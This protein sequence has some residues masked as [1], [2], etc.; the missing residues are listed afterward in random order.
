MG[1]IT[2]VVGT[3]IL[4][5]VAHVGAPSG[6][7]WQ[8]LASSVLPEYV[9]NTVL[10]ALGV[11][12]VTCVLGVATA[13]LVTLCRFPG[14]HFFSWALLLPLAIPTY[15]A[16]YAYSDLFQFAGPVQTG[17]RE[18]FGWGRDDYWFPEVRSLSG[19]VGILSLGLYPYVYLAART[20]FLEQ[21]VCV[22][23]VGRTL[24]L[25]PWRSFARIALP[26]ARPSIL[27]GLSLVLM[28]TLAEFGAVEY[29]AVNTFATGIYRVFTQPNAYALTAAAQLS[30]CL[31]GLVI[32]LLAAESFARRAARFHHTSTRY[33]RLPS[34]RLRGSRGALA[35]VAC[36]LPVAAGFGLPL[37]I[38]IAK[39]WRFGDARAR[40][41]FFE[42]GRNTFALAAVASL[43]AVALAL[44]V[45]FCR[46]LDGGA[47][48]R[49]LARLAGIGYAI[50]GGVIAIGILITVT[51]ADHRAQAVAGALFGTAP[52][53]LWSGTAVALVYGYQTRFLAVS[54]S[55]VQAGLTRI[56]PSVDG[57]ARTLGA[58]PFGMVRRV[59]LPLLRGTLLS[60]ALLVFVDVIKELPATLIL[61]PFDFD[62]LAV[63]VYHLASD[64]RLDE[65]ST[66]ALA[67]I[68]VGLVPVAILS[69]MLERSRPGARDLRPAPGGGLDDGEPPHPAAPLPPGVL[70]R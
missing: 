40:E 52:G 37:L 18:L 69:R 2:A 28:E 30:A 5:V 7:L 31:L 8:H 68:L 62:T 1:L 47:W 54:L 57:A 19:A 61:R 50:P 20:A 9:R 41:I 22:L 70:A 26:L 44:A 49:V 12:T 67:I 45:A 63:R 34:W 35:A 6:G 46:R 14:R 32:L 21:S 36:A 24:G 4:V 59:H 10:L 33:R 51:W 55:F 56:R 60:A 23:E 3:P 13:W 58:S 43:L 11:G 66:G 53:M 65:A 39:T 42:I 38:F 16:A 27:A 15:L 25:G 29:C 48:T 17:L 64:E